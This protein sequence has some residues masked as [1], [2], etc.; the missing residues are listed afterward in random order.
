[1]NNNYLPYILF[2][3]ELK[4]TTNFMNHKENIWFFLK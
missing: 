3:D 2:Y 1:M 4:L